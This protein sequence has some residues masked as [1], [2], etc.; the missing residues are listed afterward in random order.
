MN[1]SVV[2]RSEGHSAVAAAAYRAGEKLTEERT[3]EVHDYSRRG[4]VN[5]SEIL[6][7]PGSPAW[8]LSRETLWNRVESAE[9]RQDAQVAR[10]IRVAIPCELS[11]DAGRD[12]VRDY[13]RREF[14]DRGMVADVAWHDEDG[15]NPHS[16]ILLTMRRIEHEDFGKKAREWNGREPILGWREAWADCANQ[17]LAAHGSHE[18]ID[19]R[20]L[21]AQRVDAEARG[22]HEAALR[23][24]RPPTMH[25]GK[26]LTH[27]PAEAAPDRHLRFADAEAERLM[28]IG[29]AARVTSEAAAQ[30][31]LGRELD[32][33]IGEV[34]DAIPAETRAERLANV[35]QPPAV[36]PLPTPPVIE[37]DVLMAEVA[38]RQA[39]R[40]NRELIDAIP[41]ETRAER[42]ANVRQPPAVTPLPTPPVIERD[43][44]MAEVARRQADRENRELIDAIPAE[45]RAERLANVRRPPEQ[46]PLPRPPEIQRDVLMA[47]V[48]RREKERID[49]AEVARRETERVAAAKAAAAAEREAER[50]AAAEAKRVAAA[51]AAAAAE[52]EAER[53]AAAEAAKAAERE[54]QIAAAAR[55]AELKRAFQWAA[56][57]T[58]ADTRQAA[59]DLVATQP[60]G[61]PL[62]RVDVALYGRHS[63]PDDHRY[64]ERLDIGHGAVLD[65]GTLR[66]DLEA[67][68][69]DHATKIPR[70]RGRSAV[71]PVRP[72][73]VA[74]AVIAMV[75]RIQ[76]AADRLLARIL[77]RVLPDREAPTLTAPA[78]AAAPTVERGSAQGG[79]RETG[80][81]P[82]RDVG[83]PPDHDTG[84]SAPRPPGLLPG[85]VGVDD[86]DAE[87]PEIDRGDGYEAGGATKVARPDLDTPAQDIEPG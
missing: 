44:L 5:A 86:K 56:A 43:V 39:D 46:R 68:I 57:D 81:P 33:A 28:A 7:P 2:K 67:D 69:L 54:E 77:D 71:P 61:L 18:R 20:T 25:R 53:V 8:A 11:R 9:R 84:R 45:T 41:A 21:E 55:A 10:E 59:S 4:G 50:V 87:A 6:A 48:A 75:E 72:D 23:L 58:S 38:R 14:V 85:G 73:T 76:A 31:R 62:D 34:L 3:G 83:A 27:R 19:H 64:A 15:P 13:V 17:A 24:D 66:R 82:P 35:R 78:H 70:G 16:H 1:A 37:R 51:K 30:T 63:A 26:V 79:G 40:E 60:A 36:T 65:I 32:A 22:D 52:R 12:L 29:L 47:E 80:G 42:L 74:D 49:A